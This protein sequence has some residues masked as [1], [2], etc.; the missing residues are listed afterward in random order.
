MWLQRLEEYSQH[1][2]KKCYSNQ[3][4]PW[5]DSG[6]QVATSSPYM[7][8]YML[9]VFQVDGRSGIRTS[10]LPVASTN[11]NLPE[12]G[13]TWIEGIFMMIRSTEVY[14]PTHLNFTVHNQ[15]FENLTPSE[16]HVKCAEHTI[17]M[18]KKIRPP[19]SIM[20]VFFPNQHLDFVDH[21]WW[22]W[23]KQHDGP[24]VPR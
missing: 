7:T 14:N 15:H 1:V 6:E 22:N 23:Y 9:W 16:N 18:L 3:R 21:I 12:E 20:T 11:C 2:Q 10:M 13:E 8:S 4:I 5:L 24:D 17:Q 19:I